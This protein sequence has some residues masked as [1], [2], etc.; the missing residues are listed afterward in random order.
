MAN[1]LNV[2]PLVLFFVGLVLCF[3]RLPHADRRHVILCL[4][5]GVLWATL[6]IFELSMRR[7]GYAITVGTFLVFSLSQALRRRAGSN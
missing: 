2:L 7:S 5:A 4:L 3:W 6:P 1:I